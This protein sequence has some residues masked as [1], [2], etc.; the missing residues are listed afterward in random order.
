MPGLNELSTG[1]YHP[2]QGFIGGSSAS[3]VQDVKQPL[4]PA[5]D[6][7][8]KASGLAAHTSLLW[9]LGIFATLV[10]YRILYEIAE[11]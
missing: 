2:A 9:W 11:E 6:T 5:N 7:S 8:P 10:I 1:T 3:A 4:A